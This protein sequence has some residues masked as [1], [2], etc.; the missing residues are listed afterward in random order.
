MRRRAYLRTRIVEIS[1]GT[2]IRLSSRARRAAPVLLLIGAMF[3]GTAAWLSTSVK[4]NHW[5]RKGWEGMFGPP[6]L[7]NVG[8]HVFAQL[9]GTGNYTVTALNETGAGTSA[10]NGTVAL[11]IDAAG[12]VAG[13]Y[14]DS[15]LSAHGFVQAANG[16]VS[17]FDAPNAGATLS[18]GTYP[19]SIDSN[20]DIAGMYVDLNGDYHGFTRVGGVLS[21]YDAPG[22]LPAGGHRGTILTG[23]NTA[24]TVVGS[25][26]GAGSVFHGFTLTAGGS[27]TQIDAHDAGTGETYLHEQGTFP[28]AIDAAGDVAGTYVDSGN[29]YHGFVVPASSTLV[30]FSVPGAVTGAVLGRQQGTF[31]VSMDAAGD[32]VGSYTDA[33]GARHGFL[34]TANGT[35]T[36]FDAPGAVA[37]TTII[38]GTVPFSIDPSGNYIVGAYTDASGLLHGFVL[39]TANDTTTS[40][41]APGVTTN[42]KPLGEW[43]P[44]GTFGF[45]VNASG[46]FIGTYA[47]SS[48]VLHGFIATPL[49]VAA[50]PTFSPVA[51][52][53]TSA[54][55]VAINDTTPGATIYYTTNGTTPT[56]S[57][58]VYSGSITVS[59]TET[60]EAIAEGNGYASSAIGVAAYTITIPS[61]PSPTLTS[62]SPAFTGSGGSAFTLTIAGTGFVSSSTAYWGSTALTTTYV[63]G[64]QLTAQ[65]PAADIAS[66]GITAVT[67]QTPAPGGGRYA[68]QFETDSGSS[69]SAPTFTSPTTVSVAP[70]STATYSVTL[71]SGATNVSVTCLN[72]PQGAS[73][74]Y[75]ATSGA[76]TITTAANTPAGTYQITMV[77]TE[78]LPGAATALIILPFL[79]LPLAWA[80]RRWMRQQI[81]IAACIGLILFIGAVGI[82]CGG[83][84]GGGGGGKSQTHTVTSSAVVTLTVQ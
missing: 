40:F 27:F 56:T 78:T 31:P 32:L 19:L 84:S 25:Y 2:A 82:G 10:L 77:F 4:A 72:P 39:T 36:P 13:I 18:E 3:A 74:S 64:T 51:G 55:T 29:L 9:G 38:Q 49:P 69:G 61:N 11:C 53:Y 58:T 59:S 34:R 63:S 83:G 47:D 14:V 22:S 6:L 73:C 28:V 81:W 68:L 60:I 46:V 5:V 35:I 50:M 65:V 41:D 8:P 71:P 66:A 24:G 30:E 70:G 16:T 15:S 42:S 43:V 75:S 44:S 37:G 17:T 1:I 57:S 80:R 12:D 33:S 23:I 52:P 26:S 21:E 54:Q 45:G 7:S 48:M 79:L 20:G 76:V 67:V 62:L